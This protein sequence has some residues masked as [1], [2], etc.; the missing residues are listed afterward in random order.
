MFFSFFEIL[1]VPRCASRISGVS[2]MLR[3]CECCCFELLQFHS[4]VNSSEVSGL[5]IR[6]YE[7]SELFTLFLLNFSSNDQD[8]QKKPLQFELWQ[9][10]SS[11]D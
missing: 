9:R 4:Q 11:P 3:L 7:C 5:R 6:M 1:V 2:E 8:V 10:H